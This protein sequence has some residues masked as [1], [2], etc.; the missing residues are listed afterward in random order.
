R[1]VAD[2]AFLPPSARVIPTW[3]DSLARQASRPLGGPLGRHAA[4]GRQWFLTPLRVTLL[5][6]VIV[7][8]IGW[9]F[10]APCIQQYPTDGAL[11][12]DWRASRQYVAMCYSDVVP[13][14]SAERLSSGGFPYRDSWLQRSDRTAN[15]TTNASAGT[16]DEQRRYMEYPVLTGMFQWANAK[17]TE[18]WR[19]VSWLPT[20]LPVAVYFDISAFWL[21][22]AWLVT[23]W[24]VTMSNRRRPW[25]AALLALSP[26]VIVHAFTN[27]D[28]IATAFAATGMLAWARRRPGLAGVLLGLGAAA[29]L[30]PL[31]LLFPLLVLCLR[32]GR[33][34]AWVRTALTTAA[35]WVA[36]NLPFALLFTD[37]W[38]EFFR[39]NTSRGADPDS[40]YNVLGYFTGWSGFDAP[41]STPT[42]L[43]LVT[44]LLFV[45]GCAG[46]GWVALSAPRRP[47]VAQ[48]AFLLVAV[49]LLTN[50]V[51]SPQYSLWLV[52]LAVLAVP[53]TKLLLGWMTIEAVLW[54]PRM[55]YY[56][57][58]ANLAAHMPDR[59]LPQGWFLSMVVLRDLTVV[60]LCVVVLREIYTPARDLVRV[61]GDDDPQGGVLDEAAD[62]LVVSW[63]R[64]WSL[65]AHAPRWRSAMRSSTVRPRQG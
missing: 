3:T 8:S 48:L 34:D 28:T 57:E 32:A 33:I 41:G 7:L 64:T 44:T 51:W 50:K 5:F 12:L 58:Q 54:A 43:N 13:L 17:L 2:T 40:L 18:G 14:Y 4:V 15:R 36:V 31:F 10:K 65:A 24:A 42:V 1:A 6:A 21:A 38:L 22:L 46:V 26:L 56:L 29:K 39:R 37:G 16:S 61:V 62:A 45:A 35:T 49:F 9:L 25:D 47:R 23:V 52:P 27:F 60:G 11:H 20:G 59:G 55:F 19:A 30:Y 63:P 53:R